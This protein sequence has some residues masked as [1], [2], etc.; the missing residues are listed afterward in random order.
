MSINNKELMRLFI[1]N[2]LTIDKFNTVLDKHRLLDFGDALYVLSFLSKQPEF[3][4]NGFVFNNIEEFIKSEPYFENYIYEHL[5]RALNVLLDSDFVVNV[6]NENNI[7]NKKLAI[8][9]DYKELF[10]I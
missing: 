8:N 7:S 4:D 1:I 9:P 5:V 10:E 2:D 6:S 3:F